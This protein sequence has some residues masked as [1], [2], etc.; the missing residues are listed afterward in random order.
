MAA[1]AVTGVEEERRPRSP[2]V[3]GARTPPLSLY[4]TLSPT[5]DMGRGRCV[6]R[7]HWGGYLSLRGHVNQQVSWGGV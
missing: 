7:F 5:V 6:L 4:L 1:R 2:N 3:L